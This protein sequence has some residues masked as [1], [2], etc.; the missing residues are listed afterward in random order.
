VLAL[1]LPISSAGNGTWSA[2]GDFSVCAAAGSVTPEPEADASEAAEEGFQDDDEFHD[3]E[4][5][6]EELHE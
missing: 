1:G 5:Q 6:D 2:P 4:L 3:G